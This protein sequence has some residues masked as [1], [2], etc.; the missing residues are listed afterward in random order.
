MAY[1]TEYIC[2]SFPF[3][4][5]SYNMDIFYYHPLEA[6]H[7]PS[8]SDLSSLLFDIYRCQQ[9]MCRPVPGFSVA[10]RKDAAAEL[11][12]FKFPILL[13]REN[14]PCG[15]AAD[16]GLSDAMLYIYENFKADPC[17]ITRM[18]IE[19]LSLHTPFGERTTSSLIEIYEHLL[20]NLPEA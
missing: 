15:R 11:D 14:C 3:I 10:C 6:P 9:E 4:S 7:H 5:N 17:R 18:L 2:T 13:I 1:K 19:R 16:W 12:Y 8:Q 20:A